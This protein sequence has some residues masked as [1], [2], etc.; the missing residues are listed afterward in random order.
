MEAYPDIPP[1]QPWTNKKMNHNMAVI[2]YLSHIYQRGHTKIAWEILT[3]PDQTSVG[4][5]RASISGTSIMYRFPCIVSSC[6]L[7]FHFQFVETST[8]HSDY[9]AL[10]DEGILIDISHHSE[11][12]S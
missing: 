9:V 1:I 7:S 5:A 6:V 11:N 12:V 4:I 3:L 10:R 8:I 2:L